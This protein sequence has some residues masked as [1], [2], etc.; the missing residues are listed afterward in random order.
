MIRELSVVLQL[1]NDKHTIRAVDSI[2]LIIFFLRF[3]PVQSDLLIF[4]K[5][6]RE[7]VRVLE[8]RIE[9]VEE[10][11][12]KNLAKK[13]SSKIVRSFHSVWSDDWFH[14]YVF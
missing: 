13:T 9:T 10:K 6:F 7:K 1:S 5:E 14:S 2:S 4:Q 11:N 12:K 3:F 8:L